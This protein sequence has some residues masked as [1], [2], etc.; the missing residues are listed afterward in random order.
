MDERPMRRVTLRTLRR[1]M[2]RQPLWNG[3]RERLS[4]FTR[5]DPEKNL[6]RSTWRKFPEYAERYGQAVHDPDNA[7]LP[8]VRLSSQAE[9]DRFLA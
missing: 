4:N 9:I 8:F 6:I 7:H 3:N 2:T 1:A 5:L